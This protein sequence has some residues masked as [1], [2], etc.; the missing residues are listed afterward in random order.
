MT[1]KKETIQ[2]P[3]GK[4][5]KVFT[6][7]RLVIGTAS[8]WRRMFDSNPDAVSSIEIEL[9]ALP[10]DGKIIIELEE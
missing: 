2:I 5:L 10:L 4:W 1:T 7:G 6:H 3:A 9:H 8:I